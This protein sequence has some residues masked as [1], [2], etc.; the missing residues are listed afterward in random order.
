MDL[1]DQHQNLIHKY[2]IE[3]IKSMEAIVTHEIPADL[4]NF[5]RM[6]AL[7]EATIKEKDNLLVENGKLK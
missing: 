5:I 7:M 4:E 2:E 3:K 6:E 1:K